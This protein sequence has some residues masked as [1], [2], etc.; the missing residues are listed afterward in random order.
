M[1]LITIKSLKKYFNM[2]GT[3]PASPV[4]MIFG[5]CFKICLIKNGILKIEKKVLNI[6]KFFQF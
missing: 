6:S 3:N 5:L 4:I 2:H 1:L